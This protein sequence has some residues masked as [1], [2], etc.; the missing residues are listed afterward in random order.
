MCW[1]S[2][3]V[4]PGFLDCGLVEIH[5][6]GI[7]MDLHLIMAPKDES[8]AYSSGS[9]ASESSPSTVGTGRIG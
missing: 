4:N 9:Q 3:E 7:A 6:L 1:F 5:S 2:V 8:R